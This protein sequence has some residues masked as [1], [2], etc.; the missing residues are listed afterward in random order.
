MGLNTLLHNYASPQI[1]FLMA[2]MRTSNISFVAEPLPLIS[3]RF[4]LW[5]AMS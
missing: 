5:F 1:D 4:R 3:F 2:A